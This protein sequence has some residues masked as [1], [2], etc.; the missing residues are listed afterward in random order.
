MN[1][2]TELFQSHEQV[3]EVADQAA[4]VTLS[5]S[6]LDLV[7]GGQMIAVFS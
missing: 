3:E 7:G 1:T 4:D 5:W 2:T 6:D